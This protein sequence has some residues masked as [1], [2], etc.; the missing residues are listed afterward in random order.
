[1]SVIPVVRPTLKFDLL[2]NTR[3]EPPAELAPP[4][5][6][7][8]ELEYT[9][10]VAFRLNDSSGA[11]SQ[12][13]FSTRTTGPTSGLMTYITVG[14]GSMATTIYGTSDLSSTVPLGGWDP[15][16]GEWGVVG[17]SAHAGVLRSVGPGGIGNP[18]TLPSDVAAHRGPRVGGDTNSSSNAFDGEILLAAIA[19]KGLTPEELIAAYE[20]ITS[21]LGLED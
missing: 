20:A 14:S 7:A 1:M 10:F 16:G 11:G 4:D 5:G 21:S 12:A 15:L 18:V 6:P 13:L 9:A 8:D 17:F 19:H 2:S 3:V